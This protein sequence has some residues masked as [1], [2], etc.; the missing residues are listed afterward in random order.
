M[1]IKSILM[2]IEQC[3]FVAVESYLSEDK[4]NFELESNGTSKK[5]FVVYA[6]M[7]DRLVIGRFFFAGPTNRL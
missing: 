2:Y 3:I 4:L 1:N 6:C 7:K 5:L